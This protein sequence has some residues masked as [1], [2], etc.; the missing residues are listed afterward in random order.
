MAKVSWV[1]LA[2]AL[3]GIAVATLWTAYGPAPEVPLAAQVVEPTPAL[4]STPSVM[5]APPATEVP[6]Q[7]GRVNREK[8]TNIPTVTIETHSAPEAVTR[9]LAGRGLGI[10]WIRRFR[11][12]DSR[13]FI[14]AVP[15]LQIRPAAP[16]RN[17]EALPGEWQVTLRVT[18]DKSGRLMAAT[19]QNPSANR[20][21]VRLAKNAIERWSFEPARLQKRPVPSALDVTF[22]FHPVAR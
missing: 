22:R 13:E 17:A 2:A 4:Q 12:K 5:P 9:K 1:P 21:F 10:P 6:R 3:F 20:E 8:A 18:L 14:Q 11:S 15:R 16:R 7:R 19:L